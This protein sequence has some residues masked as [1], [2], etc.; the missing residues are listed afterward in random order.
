MKFNHIVVATLFVAT[1]CSTLVYAQSDFAAKS[2]LNMVAS[3]HPLATEAGVRVFEQGGN[4]VDAAIATA[5]TLGVVDGH[6]SGIGGGCFILIRREDGKIF[7]VDGREMAPIAANRDMY[8]KNGKPVGRTSQ[9]GPLAIGVPGALKA[10]HQAITEHGTQKWSKL[11]NQAAEIA[12][13]G[14]EI[15]ELYSSRIEKERSHISKFESTAK[16]LLKADG[17]IF[18]AGETLLQKDLAKTYRAIAQDGIGW[19]YSK[20][21]PAIVESWMS[22]NEGILTEQDFNNYCTKNRQPIRSTYRG[23]EIVGFPPPSSGGI[24]VAQILNILDSFNLKKLHA[25]NPAMLKHVVIEAMKLAFADRAHWLGDSDFIDVPKQLTSKSYAKSLASKI[26][27][28]KASEVKSHGIPPNADSEFFDRQTTHLTTADS[29]GNWVAITTTLNTRFGSK[30]VI[31]GTGV[32]MNNQMDDFSIAPGVPNAYGLIGS[33][34]NSVAAGKRPLSSMSPTI[35]LKDGKPIFTVGAA[36]GPKIIT[37]SVWAIINH[38]D[39][40]MSVPDAIAAARVH[41]Q[42]SPDKVLA[43]ETIEPA[44][45]KQLEQ[46][47]HKLDI[48]KNTSVGFAQAIG[49]DTKNQEFTG[50][51]DPRVKGKAKGQ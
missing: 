11:M 12:E 5:L 27:F 19:F 4:A 32:I 7:A 29:K 17:S 22:T 26:D 9:I 40:S 24:H 20:P 46:L 28:S 47:G 3:V 36:G 35:V 37:Q 8:L 48:K 21:F 33:E 10:Y 18:H 39:L 49:F 13:N 51:H 25:Q 2:K 44:I 15:S 38:L 45:R 14:F 41:H 6:N 34:N 31:P 43:E 23:Y 1:T 30:V 42:W 16:I 50:A